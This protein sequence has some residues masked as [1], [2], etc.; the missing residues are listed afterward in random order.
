MSF[1]FCIASV[2]NLM[3]FSLKIYRLKYEEIGFLKKVMFVV[4]NN[5]I[6]YNI[7]Y[8]SEARDNV[9]SKIIDSFINSLMH[10]LF[11]FLNL[12]LMDS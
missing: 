3:L 9:L 7:L 1:I 4:L 6:I 2:L 8:C 11:L 10:S 5:L 12:V